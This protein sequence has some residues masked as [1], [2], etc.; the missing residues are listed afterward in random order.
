MVLRFPEGA[1]PLSMPNQN[2][3]FTHVTYLTR[4]KLESL[5]TTAGLRIV[6]YRDDVVSSNRLCSLGWTGR[7]VL[8]LAQ[9]YARVLSAVVRALLAPL[10]SPLRLTANSVAMLEV[11]PVDRTSPRS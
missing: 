7:L 2:G 10:N 9:L 1:S 3:D 11:A 4:S 6:K 5:A 8:H